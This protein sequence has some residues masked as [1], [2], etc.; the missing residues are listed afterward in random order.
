MNMQYKIEYFSGAG[1]LFSVIDNRNNVIDANLLSQFAKLS[2]SKSEKFSIATEGLIVLNKSDNNPFSV[3][4]FNP[5][6]S[7]GMMCGNGARCAV[8]F[9]EMLRLIQKGEV[10]RPIKFDLA[11]QE[12]LAFIDK[13]KIKVQFPKPRYQKFNIKVPFQ[14]YL[15]IGDFIDVGTPHIIFKYE[16]IPNAKRFAFRY[17]PI[18]D[19]AKPIRYNSEQFPDGVNV[20][21][22]TIENRRRIHLRTY[23]RGVE[24]E[25]GACG[26]ASVSTAFTLF[27]KGL[28][29]FKSEIIPTSYNPLIVENIIDESD[30]VLGFYLI[31]TADKI[32]EALIEF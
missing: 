2:C 29:N 4:F 26:T 25:T 32:G 1:N 14:E 10:Q 13:D 22:Y 8:K 3:K 7:S 21:I 12:Y 28:I 23:E 30:E 17:Y 24:H 11:G 27:K 6:G 9:A 20:S 15:V 18:D 19:F 5:D 31:G 16:E